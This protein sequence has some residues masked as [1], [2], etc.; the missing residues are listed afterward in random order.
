M[1]RRVELEMS[2]FTGTGDDAAHRAADFSNLDPYNRP[3]RAERKVL[4][5]VIVAASLVVGGLALMMPNTLPVNAAVAQTAPQK[6]T[7]API[8]MAALVA[9]PKAPA[10]ITV[11]KAAPVSAAADVV[12]SPPLATSAPAISAARAALEAEEFE[13]ALSLLK[14]AESGSEVY[15]LRGWAL[16]ELGKDSQAMQALKRALL[17]QPDHPNS[18]LL[19][20]ELQQGRDPQA[21]KK[22]YRTYLEHYPESPQANEIRTILERS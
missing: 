11:A 4:A 20:G 14:D 7:P 17:E 8:S 9:T 10:S 21:A 15:A 19:L 3:E 12:K 13:K 22:T 18:L 1:S 2:F 16:Y 5:G 6:T